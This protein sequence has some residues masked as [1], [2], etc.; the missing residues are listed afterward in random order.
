MGEDAP[1]SPPEAS[2]PTRHSTPVPET[3]WCMRWESSDDRLVSACSE[4]SK[5]CIDVSAWKQHACLM[6]DT[7]RFDGIYA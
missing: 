2:A 1:S 5:D 6:S 3:C 7:S 4:A